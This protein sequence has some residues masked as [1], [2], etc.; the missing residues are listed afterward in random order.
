VVHTA[1]QP[2]PESRESRNP[3]ARTAP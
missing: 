3:W 1:T 2:G